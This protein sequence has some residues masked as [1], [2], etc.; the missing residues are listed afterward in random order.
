MSKPP[1][2]LKKLLI[3]VVSMMCSLAAPAQQ[4]QATL[5]HYT[6]YDGMASNAISD[7]KSDAYGYIWIATW[8]GLSRFDGYHFFNY[9]TGN[10]SGV[11]L[12]HN[13]IF[14]ITID[15]SQNIWLRKYDGRVYVLNRLT[16]TIQSAFDDVEGGGNFITRHNLTVTSKGDVIA[17][18]RNVGIYVMRL[19]RD[20]RITKR[21][22]KTEPL[23]PVSVVED[24]HGHLYVGTNH[25]IH[26]LDVAAGTL[27]RDSLF[28]DEAMRCMYASGDRIYA[29][30]ASGKLLRFTCG[31]E[32]EALADL[33]VPISS[34]FVDSH[35]LIWFSQDAQGVSRLI[36]EAGNVKHFTQYVLVPQYDIKGAVMAEMNGTVWISMNHGGFGYYNRETD[37]VEY[38]HNDPSNMWNLLNTVDAFTLL[39]EGVL[40][41][42]TVRKGLEKL[43]IMQSIIGRE[44]L[45]NDASGS[46]IN[47]LRAFCYDKKRRRLLIGNKMSTLCVL[48]ANGTRTDITTDDNGRPLGRIYG[49]SIDRAGNYWIASK[50][51]GLTVMTPRADGG[52]SFRSYVHSDATSGSISSNNTYCTVEDRSGNI[53]I[54]TYG[55]GVNLLL[56]QKDGSFRVLHQ[57]NGLSKYPKESHQNVRTLTL[58]KNDNVWAGTTD[59]LLLMSCHNGKFVIED[60]KPCSNPD[61]IIGSTDVICLACDTAGSVWVGTNGGGLSHTVG[62]DD[63][64]R[65]MFESFDT[66][67]GLP[68]AEIRSLVFDSKGNA[69]IATEHELVSFDTDK[70]VFSVF[71]MQD[72]V[73]NTLCSEC[74]ALVMPDDNVLFGTLNGYYVVDRKKLINSSASQIKLNITDFLIDDEIASPRLNK[75]LDYYVPDSTMVT[76]PRHGCKFSFRFA[77]LN[78]Q[79]QHRVVYQYM[80]EGYDKDWRNGDATHMAHYDGL[81]TGTYRFHVKAYLLESPDNYDMRTVLV[82]VPPYPLFSSTA[83]WFY[84]ILLIIIALTSIFIIQERSRRSIRRRTLRVG[85][86]YM[87]FDKIEDYELMDRLLKWLELNYSNP[88][89]KLD[90]LVSQSSLGRAAY[91]NQMETLTQMSPKEFI[92][93]FRLKKAIELLDTRPDLTV[94]AIFKQTGFSDP[95]YFA[96]MFKKKT[97][98]SP[99]EYWK[100][101]KK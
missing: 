13:R 96:Q 74:A 86:R 61:Y 92:T 38:F 52:Y 41:E 63:D 1:A 29:G 58:D 33:Q 7:I 93:D 64:G 18:I 21:L 69:W 50:G 82:Q 98:V 89:L 4:L 59:G 26:Q 71:S 84:V 25:G 78:F 32:P 15:H 85:H 91:I 55:G 19:E 30:T 90:D 95:I 75:H 43:E 54:A 34:L 60:V 10:R 81:P 88:E 45:F 31:Q 28:E 2:L 22:I 37:E 100:R 3:V 17:L 94:S 9:A 36:P 47:E 8:N 12:L 48:E 6:T 76:L 20:G 5:Y 70:R 83:V 87:S 67:D 97:G 65:W 57:D 73:D 16:D 80:M 72:G 39:P 99:T 68:S 77:S 42:S 46:N 40:W 51:M 56:K 62:R 53:W 11:P 24:A 66:R 49:I 79:L 27:Q 14:S 23:N 35:E 44:R 101:K